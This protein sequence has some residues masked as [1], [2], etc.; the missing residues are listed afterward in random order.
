MNT[1]EGGRKGSGVVVSM[2]IC[3]LTIFGFGFNGGWQNE[4]YV[5][6]LSRIAS[7]SF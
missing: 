6:N 3:V 5:Q 4:E 2:H 1:L 7:F